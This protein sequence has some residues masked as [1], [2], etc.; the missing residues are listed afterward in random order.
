MIFSLLIG[1]IIIVISVIVQAM[2]NVYWLK[3]IKKKQ[4]HYASKVALTLL[5]ISFLF[6]TFLHFIQSLFWAVTYMLIPETKE[7]FISFSEAWYFSM[8]TFTS[9]GYGDYTLTPKWQ[10]LSGVEAINGIMLIGWSTAMMFSL[11]QQIFKNL[12][13]K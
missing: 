10:F 7:V 5:V 8:V 2:G 1:T 12:Y 11:I 4:E 3:Q 9:L 13:S 6:F